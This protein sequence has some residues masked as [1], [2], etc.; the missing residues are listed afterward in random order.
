MD[1]RPDSSLK[2]TILKAVDSLQNEEGNMIWTLVSLFK[3][4][5]EKLQRWERQQEKDFDVK[6]VYGHEES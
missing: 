5:C 4:S 2:S 1:E 3:I 6:K